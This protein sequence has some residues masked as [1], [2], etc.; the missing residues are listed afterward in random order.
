MLVNT[1]DPGIAGMALEAA[2]S[3]LRVDNDTGIPGCYG[4]R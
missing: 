3:N 4:F 2:M 1:L